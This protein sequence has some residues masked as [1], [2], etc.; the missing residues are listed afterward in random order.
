[1]RGRLFPPEQSSKALMLLNEK[2]ENKQIKNQVAQRKE[3]KKKIKVRDLKPKKDAK[4]GAG[5]GR[6]RPRPPRTRSGSV[7]FGSIPRYSSL[8]FSQSFASS[9]PISS[10]KYRPPYRAGMRGGCSPQNTR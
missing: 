10:K 8:F 1:M 9:H 4:G 5:N 3:I 6:R 7:L 2:Q